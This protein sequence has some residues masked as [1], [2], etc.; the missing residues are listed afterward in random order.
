MIQYRP[1]DMSRLSC[2]YLSGE[3]NRKVKQRKP[4]DFI[5]SLKWLAPVVAAVTAGAPATVAPAAVTVAA[6]VTMAAAVAGATTVAGSYFHFFLESP[7]IVK[8]L[9]VC[10]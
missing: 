1:H 7:V 10:R 8:I 3:M 6:A 5:P 4:V 2:L 9:I